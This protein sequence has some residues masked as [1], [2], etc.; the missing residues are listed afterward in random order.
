MS[1]SPRR[2]HAL[3]AE[4]ERTDPTNQEV[5]PPMLYDQLYVDTR[6]AQVLRALVTQKLPALHIQPIDESPE[7]G[8]VR[9]AVPGVAEAAVAVR[10]EAGDV[11]HMPDLDVVLG[12][13]R[14]KMR[15]EH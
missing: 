10:A 6:D 1:V 2:I 12:W 5:Y 14:E 13:I 9:W 8:L 15:Q 7:L 11:G 3:M 4:A